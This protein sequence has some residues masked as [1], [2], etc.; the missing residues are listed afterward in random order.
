MYSEKLLLGNYYMVTCFY[1]GEL[2]I[3]IWAFS[4]NKGAT[5]TLFG[6]DLRTVWAEPKLQV[7]NLPAT[8]VWIK[9]T[10]FGLTKRSSLGLDQNEPWFSSF[11]VWKGFFLDSLDFKNI[12]RKFGGDSETGNKQ[13][14][15]NKETIIYSPWNRWPL[16][17]QIPAQP[18]FLPAA[19]I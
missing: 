6:L 16:W 3:R 15:W 14:H 1:A 2:W 19:A 7:W 9:L 11:L 5:P 12:C 18:P 8:A 10:N 17:K 13:M 4:Y